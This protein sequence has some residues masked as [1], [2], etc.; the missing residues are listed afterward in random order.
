MWAYFYLFD[1]T[2]VDTFVER[3][4]NSIVSSILSSWY[5]HYTLHVCK[6]NWYISSEYRSY[7]YV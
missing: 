6:I 7:I 5:N 1:K 2:V 4:I 3:A